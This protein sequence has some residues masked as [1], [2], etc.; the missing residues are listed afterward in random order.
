MT[1]VKAS[2]IINEYRDDTN[3]YSGEIKVQDMYEM[4]RYRFEF[5]EAESKVIIA[6]L[7]KAGAKFQGEL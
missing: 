3:Y 1:K 4:F 5:G 7:V 6:S 2:E